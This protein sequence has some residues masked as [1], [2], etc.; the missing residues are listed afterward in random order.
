MKYLIY[1]VNSLGPF[2]LRALSSHD[3]IHDVD[4][5]SPS[6]ALYLTEGPLISNL[7]SIKVKTIVIRLSKDF[8]YSYHIMSIR[9]RFVYHRLRSARYI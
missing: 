4:M 3:F 1:N 7:I 2:A 5:W 9:N 6:R 8:V